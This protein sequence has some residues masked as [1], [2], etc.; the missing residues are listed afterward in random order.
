MVKLRNDLILLFQAEMR[1][2]RKK[3]GFPKLMDSVLADAVLGGQGL[4]AV[5]H[6]VSASK[7][8]TCVSS[9]IVLTSHSHLHHPFVTLPLTHYKPLH[10]VQYPAPY[11]RSPT[12]FYLFHAHGC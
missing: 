3:S 4:T 5:L 8:K 6:L 10:N 7:D 1:G 12:I 9:S 11:L 2:V